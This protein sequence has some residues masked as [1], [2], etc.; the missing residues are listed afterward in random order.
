MPSPKNTTTPLQYIKGVGPVRSAALIEMGIESVRDLLYNF[1]RGYLD[2]SSIVRIADLASHVDTGRQVTV[3]GDVFRQE[4]RRARRSNRMMFFL[5][6]KDESGFLSCVWFEGF[7]WYKDAFEIGET[8]AMSAVPK[9][10]KLGRPQFIHPQFDRLK[11]VEE[12]EPDWGRMF[13]TG[14]IIPKYRSTA[15]LA[16][17]G[18]DSRGFRRIIRN[19]LSSHR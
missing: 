16:K 12:D 18:L 3:I 10:D 11:G 13:N 14:A 2:R 4:G 7:K 6:L 19:A 9:L 1:P 17:I 8:L 15:E 5:T